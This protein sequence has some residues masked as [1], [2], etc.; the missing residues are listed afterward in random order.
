MKCTFW[1]AVF[2]GSFPISKAKSKHCERKWQ[3]V[4]LYQVHVLQSVLMAEMTGGI[5][6]SF[7]SP[8]RPSWR[9]YRVR[10]LGYLVD[11]R[12][13]HALLN[14]VVYL[15]L[16][17][18]QLLFPH[19]LSF[20]PS[21]IPP[22]LLITVPSS[23]CVLHHFPLCRLFLMLNDSPVSTFH[24]S[25]PTDPSNLASG[26]SFSLALPFARA[27][28]NSHTKR[29]TQTFLSLSAL[30]L[31]GSSKPIAS[32]TAFVL[33]PKSAASSFIIPES[34]QRRKEVIIRQSSEHGLSRDTRVIQRIKTIHMIKK[35]GI[36]YQPQAQKHIDRY[37]FFSFQFSFET[38]T[39]QV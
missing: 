36:V 38:D 13:L 27:V 8:P 18:T 35:Q 33:Q 7:P 32:T 19:F 1:W 24:N 3:T 23:F 12:M 22:F 10:D 31:S 2:D 28:P 25:L 21:L 34:Q 5:F 37:Y 17:E 6:W 20:L 11:P 16:L 30:L 9:N 4:L 26:C 29:L 14:P 15:F 39:I